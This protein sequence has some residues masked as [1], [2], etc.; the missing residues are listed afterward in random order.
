MESAQTP[1]LT[2]TPAAGATAGAHAP[3]V[4]PTPADTEALA[5][6]ELRKKFEHRQSPAARGLAAFLSD[7]A[8]TAKITGKADERT[9]IIDQGE[10]VTYALGPAAVGGL[11]GHLEAL[12]REGLTAHFSERQGTPAAPLSGLMLDYDVFVADPAARLQ[13]RHIQRVACQV[14]RML[15]R[16]LVFEP[17]G[18]RELVLHV[19]TIVKTAPALVDAGEGSKA[20][21][22]KY[23]FHLL[24]PGIRVSRGYKKYLLRALREDA[25]VAGVLADLGALGDP[26]ECLDMNSASVPVLFLG[27]CKRG[28]S[29]YALGS[30][31]EV[32]F[33]AAFAERG[34]PA[35]PPVDESFYPMVRALRP[36]DLEKE[37]YNLVAEAAVCF[38]A[39]YPGGRRPLAP[40]RACVYRPELA[41]EIEDLASRT[42][43]GVLGEAELL[44]AEHSL[45][46]L[47]IHDPEARHLHQVLD[48]LDASYYS[49][50]NK[51]RNVIFA[52][53]N[54]SET[55]KPLAEWFSHKCPAKWADGG[56][57]SLDQVW[58]D[59]VARRGAVANPLTKRSLVQWAR[60]CNPERFR[61]ISEQHYF[62]ILAKYVYD[63]GGLLEH[64][65]VAEVLHAMLGNKF[66]V[67]VDEGHR[68]KFT[69]CWFE[70]VVPGQAACAG[71]TWKW[72]KEIEPDELHLY[73]SQNLVKVFDQVAA[74]IDEQR[75]DAENEDKAKYYQKLG[76]MFQSTKRKVFN[77]TFKNGVIKQANYLFRRRGFVEGL[78]AEPS[79]L[80]VANGVLRLGPT[81]T[82]ID[83]FHEYPIMKFTPV[84]YRPFDPANPWVR[85]MLDAFADIVPEPDVRDWILF[86]A[87]SSLAGGVKEGLLLLWQGGGAN[88]KTFVMRM[89]AKALGKLHYAKKLKIAL[90]TSESESA[91]KPNSAVMQLEGCRFGYCEETRKCEPLND[92]R[93]K[94]IVNPGEISARDLN[95]KQ[96]N[97]EI[98]ANIMIGQNYNFDIKG[99]SD[100]GTWRRI[101]HYTS[102]VRFCSNPDPSNPFEKRDDQRYVRE[103]PNDPACQEATLS[104]LAHYYERLHRE[105]GGCVKNVPCPT[106]DRE[107]ES[108]RNEQDTINR[109]IT[110]CVVLSPERAE[111]YTL[112]AVAGHYIDWY[113]ENIDRRRHVASEIIQDLENSAL[114]PHVRRAPNRTFNLHGCRVLTADHR[115]L[116]PGESYLGSPEEDVDDAP[117]PVL[118]ASRELWWDAPPPDAAPGA[119][120]GD[121]SDEEFLE[122][123][124][125][126]TGFDEPG[127]LRATPRAPR[128]VTDGAVDR[129]VA[130]A[131][132]DTP[133]LTAADVFEDGPEGP[134]ADGL[135]G[136]DEIQEFV[137]IDE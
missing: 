70:F 9:N 104:I 53:A 109:F 60:G 71:E 12:R 80:G 13:E 58:D 29:P 11:F 55:Y 63:F 17:A 79:L 82:L 92:Q 50:R 75:A 111:P 28:G 7:P 66:V 74:H 16:D 76:A 41:S 87:A 57:D 19:F 90:F 67:D 8:Q 122:P 130:D 117:A 39:A 2:E 68:G 133:R 37:G 128:A 89:I 46:T 125:V 15:R 106:L 93:L 73:L 110:E 52:L 21:K 72:R 45:S 14:V 35:P 59:A 120:A 54:T 84:A 119:D 32:A 22:Y 97:F 91:D 36:D 115:G 78:D 113:N 112:S 40:A 64:F 127:S 5:R 18:G 77:D 114:R 49:D 95:S 6:E 86:F 96:K 33:D 101:K 83:H 100:H 27:S 20:P 69:Y 88:G 136:D 81:C 42:Q 116:D 137:H 30:V 108:F 38:E 135:A 102:K 131:C 134:P 103:Y 1:E 132:D 47:A 105:Y 23:G 99:L 65:M 43:N 31:L 24:V 94:E 124:C 107:S 61:Q 126:D 123:Y 51:W 10:R 3:A 121:L 118:P 44:L 26:R 56:R 48:L 34:A 129:F 25:L 62:T 4:V 85:L 98:T